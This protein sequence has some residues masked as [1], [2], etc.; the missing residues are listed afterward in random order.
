MEGL[1]AA[2]GKL[3]A[4]S[5]VD[6]VSAFNLPAATP[7]GFGMY[8]DVVFAVAATGTT[9]FVGGW[10]TSTGGAARF[11]LAA[12]DT[13]VGRL[14]P[15]DAGLSSGAF[16]QGLVVAGNTLY[17]Y[18]G[19]DAAGGQLRPGLA[20]LDVGSGAVQAF[21]PEVS[22]SVDALATNGETVFVAGSAKPPGEELRH[23]L[24]AL[25][26]ATGRALS[27]WNP[28]VGGGQVWRCWPTA[29]SCMRSAPSR[30][31]TAG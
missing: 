12:F 15:W 23:Y 16:V 5:T 3:F 17:A 7:S 27:R 22:G 8:A 21:D 29:T 13:G 4:L 6:G 24:A 9:A 11:G 25:D 30:A 31:S 26:P 18:G 28:Q 14:L 2:D 19:F 10:F 20:A 1:A